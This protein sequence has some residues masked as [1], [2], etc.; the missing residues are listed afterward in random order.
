[1]ALWG[2]QG[3]KK[4]LCRIKA[5]VLME[6]AGK[7]NRYGKRFLPGA[8]FLFLS[9]VLI[10]PSH[11]SEKIRIAVVMSASIKP[12][13]ESLAGFYDELNSL[14]IN[15]ETREFLVGN[16]GSNDY[17]S[18]RISKYA[19]LFI[20]TVGSKATKFVKKNIDETPVIFSMVLNPVA[21][22][23]VGSMRSP[24]G[25]ISGASMDIPYRQ[26]F[27]IIRGMLP[28]AKTIG[29]IYSEAETGL[30]V[31]DAEK[32]ASQF[33]FKFLRAEVKSPADLYR[34]LKKLV[35]NID[36]LWSVAD[37]NVFT[38]ETTREILIAT[39]RERIPFMGLSPAF[40][41]A[42]ALAALESSPHDMGREAAKL[43]KQVIDGK[44]PADIPVAPANDI[45]L[46]LNSNTIEVIGIK[47][48]KDVYDAAVII[49]P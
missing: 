20:H 30:V 45:K 29:I 21:S 27:K 12:Y 25:N 22:G 28:G 38:R 39:L 48:P 9:F 13:K 26:Q 2:G 35:G 19:P 44:D 23:F 10:T 7:I 24:G 3:G 11:A 18:D 47:V 40:V 6:S 33:G 15:Y 1:M 37:G 4:S 5:Q 16:G 41:R 31:A 14:G 49:N 32:I 42:G 8:L 46:Y 17:I 36:F 43:M 34:A